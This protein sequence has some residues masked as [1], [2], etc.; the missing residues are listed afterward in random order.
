MD[1]LDIMSSAFPKDEDLL[2]S[3]L[4]KK[5]REHYSSDQKY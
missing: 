3:G 4:V 2:T 1:T 5:V